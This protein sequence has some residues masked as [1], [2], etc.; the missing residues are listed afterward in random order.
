MD[1]P[2]NYKPRPY[3]LPFLVNM[4]RGKIRACL[5]WHRRSGKTKTIFN[6][7]IKKAF[8][9]VGQYFHCF[10]E[11][12][13]GRKVLWDGIDETRV[14]D[15]HCPPELR[16]ATNKQEMK[17]D[18][19]NGSLWQIIGA[20][21][22][23]AVVGTN[24]KGI[25]F[26]EFSISEKMR[27]AWDFFRPILVENGG[28][29]VFCFTP[30]GRNHAW[31][32]YQMAQRNPEW[33]CQLLTVDD[34]KA[35]SVS[36]VQKERD[37]GMSEDMIRQEFYCDFLTSMGDIVIPFKYIQESQGRNVDYNHA[38]RIAGLDVARFGNDR[39][40]IV[41]RQGG[42]VTYVE[43]W[44]GHDTVATVGKVKGLFDARMFDVLAVDTIGV[45]AGVYDML[46]NI[47]AFPVVS[48]NVAEASSDSGRFK[49]LRD[50]LWWKAREWFMD[51]N[52][53]INLPESQKKE[54]IAD[55][56]DIHFKYSPTGQ[57]V[58]DDKEEMK[59]RLEFSPDTGDAFCC[60]FSKNVESKVRQADRELFSSMPIVDNFNPLTFGLEVY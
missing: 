44:Q 7:E 56:Q 52:C 16:K 17:I 33:F 34:T 42:S 23:D 37:A 57:I 5:V 43:T 10:P 59:K 48:V 35:L 40:A 49:R 26:D 18:L 36:D 45:G 47:G 27:K 3:Q 22:Y 9:R 1:I 31:D 24:P 32:I 25:V 11:Y 15:L 41:I 28:W 50:E 38:G 60:T 51:G 39:T 54:F 20:D 46:K 19:I 6:F 53:C 30:R 12:N 13:Q 58:V 2:C 21:N 55:I 4:D 29:A 8:E 14:L